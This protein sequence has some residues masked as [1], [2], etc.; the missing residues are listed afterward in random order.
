M[1]RRAERDSVLKQSYVDFMATYS[2][3]GRMEPVPSGDARCGSTFYMPHHA[4]FKATEPSKI[5]VV[6]N[7]SFRTSTGTSL[8]DMLLPGPKLLDSRLTSG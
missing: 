3:L 5:R 2:S 1:E 8:N 6:F 4:V 7:A